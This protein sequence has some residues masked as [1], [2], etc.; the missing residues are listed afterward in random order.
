MPHNLKSVAWL[1]IASFM[2]HKQFFINTVEGCR[3]INFL[4]ENGLDN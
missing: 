2:N 1:F 4:T 3:I